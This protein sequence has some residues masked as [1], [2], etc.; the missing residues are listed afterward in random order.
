MHTISRPSTLGIHVAG[1]NAAGVADG[2]NEGQRR[3]TLGR[4]PGQRVG[5]P[6]QSDDVARVAAGDHEH[7][8]QVART[9]GRGRGGDDEGRHGDV[10]RQRDVEVA[11][12]RAV[13]V[14]GVKERGDD[15]QDVRRSRE[16]QRLDRA[17]VEGLDHRGEEVGHGAGGDDAEDEDHLE[18]LSEL[19]LH[20][21]SR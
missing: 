10:Q 5:D 4:R 21:T 8:G 18:K 2:V 3:S 9:D 19:T 13:G 6:A 17:V 15:G 16:Q 11:L 1:I 12:A 14:P 20:W 7:H